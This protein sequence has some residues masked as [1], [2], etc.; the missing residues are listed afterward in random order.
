MSSPMPS[1]EVLPQPSSLSRTASSATATGTGAPPIDTPQD[2]PYTGSGWPF[3]IR[4]MAALAIPIFLETLD[5]TVVATAQPHI[6]SSFNRL[7]LQSWIGTSYLL[8]STVFL[9][10]FASIANAFGR[11]IGIQL[12]LLLFILG[13]ALSTGARSMIMMLLGRGVA[14]VGAGGLIGVIRIIMADS[15]S[16]NEN[17]WQS[18]MLLILYASGYSLGPVVGGALVSESYR[19]VFALNLPCSVISMILVYFLLG[20][21]LKGPQ[22]HAI[23]ERLGIPPRDFTLTEKLLSIDFLGAFL[24]ISGV[25]LFLLALTWGPTFAWSSPR[26]IV[27]FALGGSL[28]M[29]C[30]VWEWCLHRYGP[31]SKGGS[32]TAFLRVVPMLPVPV[33]QNLDVLVCQYAAFVAG[34]VMFVC[35]YFVAIFFTIVSDK[36]ATKAGVDLIFFSPGIGTG[37]FVAMTLMRKLRQP[38][39]PIVIG[40]IILPLALGLISEAI[41]SNKQ[42]ELNGFMVLAGVGVGLTFGPLSIHAQFKQPEN[43]V[44]IVQALNLFFR[45]LGGTIS[46]SLCAAV[47]NSRIN[48]YLAELIASGALSPA[49]AQSLSQLSSGSIASLQVIDELPPDVAFHVREAFRQGTRWAFMSLIP[50]AVVAFALVMFLSRI[51]DTDKKTKVDSPVPETNAPEKI[52]MAVLDVGKEKDAV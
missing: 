6:A 44:A 42:G 38:K 36:S 49:N 31:E 35:F 13:S 5:Y 22:T 4:L 25:I 51:E 17:N 16:L 19:W 9:P 43:R 40:S 21:R 14:G 1:S 29:S 2:A 18:T 26:V 32:G 24:F 28:V 39:I 15:R 50:W 33:F 10:I 7:D 8:T 47:M 45:N 23:S 37:V 3:R 52:E 27:C 48:R 20:K 46:L 41:N 11:H 30:L 12:S 34:M